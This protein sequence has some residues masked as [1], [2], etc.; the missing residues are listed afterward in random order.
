MLGLN[1]EICIENGDASFS[2]VSFRE[3]Y[4]AKKQDFNDII[5]RNTKNN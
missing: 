1:E 5:S 2:F 3:I 4:F